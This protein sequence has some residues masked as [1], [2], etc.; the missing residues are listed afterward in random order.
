MVEETTDHLLLNCVFSKEV[1]MLATGTQ[2]ALN[3][4]PDLRSLLLLWDS[5]YPFAVKGKNQAFSMWKVLPKFILW[6]LWLERNNRI[7]RDNQRSA[8]MVVTKI[9][10]LFGES[11]PYL[12]NSNNN[13][14]LDEA[15]ERWLS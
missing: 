7:F 3:L 12:C 10:A 2:N 4:P 14:T 9:H 8:A 6:N 13:H 1:W 15:K 11:A 5:L